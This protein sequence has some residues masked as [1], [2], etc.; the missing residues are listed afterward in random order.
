[1]RLKCYLRTVS[2][3]PPQTLAKVA[4][5]MLRHRLASLRQRRQDANHSTYVDLLPFSPGEFYSYF[6]AIP[7]DL[8]RLQSEKISALSDNYLAHRFDLLGSGWVQVKHGMLC[9]GLEGYRF[10]MGKSVRIDREGGWLRGRINPANLIRSQRIW[11]LVDPTYAPIDW[12]LDFKSGY[13]W[14][15][16]TWYLDI[17]YGHKLGV[18]IKVPWELA[19]M[20]HLPQLAWACALAKDGQAGFAP[21]QRYVGAFRNQVLDFIAT[22]PPRFGANW[23]SSMDVGIRVANWLVT[24]DLFRASGTDF[25]VDFKSAFSHSVYEHGLHIVSNLE[26]NPELRGNHYLAHIVGLLFI[27]AYL[28]CTPETDA[29]LALAVQELVKEVGLQFNH[30]GTSFEASTCY[31]RLA[32]EL[33]LYATALV[34]GLPDSDEDQ[35]VP[36]AHM[37]P[38]RQIAAVNKQYVYSSLLKRLISMQNRNEHMHLQVD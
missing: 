33:V 21:A 16:A 28:P 5:A 7:V 24:F 4:V 34:F 2:T 20:Q 36:F 12:Q 35:P 29:W 10:E 32:A 9:R 22:N 31:H 6:R 15:E 13:R 8:L 14:T 23:R 17:P 19:R 37:K 38:H 26:W 18:D 30:D 1:M 27:A 3:L 25:D 11:R